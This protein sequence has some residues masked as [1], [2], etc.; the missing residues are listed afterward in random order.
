MDQE[1]QRQYDNYFS[2]FATEGWKQFIEDMDSILQ[3]YR[4]ED[5]QNDKHLSFVQG[6]R[7]VL[8]LIVNFE[9]SMRRTYDDLEGAE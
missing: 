4:I 6:E 7:R 2:M 5:I 9:D 8:N 3:T 1:T